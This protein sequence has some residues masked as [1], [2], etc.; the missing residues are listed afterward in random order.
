MLF[1]TGAWLTYGATLAILIGTPS[2]MARVQPSTW[3][4]RAAFALFASSL[5]AEVALFPIGAFV[6]SRVTA[7]GLVVNFAAIPLMTIAQVSGMALLAAAA[8]VPAAVPALAETA[9]RSSWGLVESARLVD[10]A[11]WVTTRLAPPA[12][13]VVVSYYLGWLIWWGVRDARWPGRR[14]IA[15]VRAVRVI[16]L[17]A[18]TGAGL[19]V[20]LAPALNTRLTGTL[21]VTFIDVGQGDATLVRAPGGHAWLIDAG[22]AGGGS[23]DVGRRIVEPVV[24]ARGV[25]RLSRLVLTHGDADHAGGAPSIV[26]DLSPSEIWEGVPVPPDPLLRAVREAADAS[27]ALWRM[28]Q[29]GD[30]VA[31]GAIQATVWHPPPADWERQRVRNDDS[32][33][34]DLRDGDVSIVL[35]G[36]VEAA[37]ESALAALLPPAPIRILLAPHHGSATSST[38]PMIRG[39]KPSLVVISVGRGNRYGHPHRAVLDRYRDAGVPVWRTDLDGAIT[40]RT[41]G[42]TAQVTSFTGRAATLGPAT[43]AAGVQRP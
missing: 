14:A 8:L 2:L 22:G 24:W 30:V 3:L 33:V 9:H 16:G 6:F 12:L 40:V 13:A 41:D 15:L 32:V 5:C 31:A 7:A 23:F 38:W 21:E 34:I 10:L 39:A 36:D 43:R 35:P 37:A 27:G 20:V 29:R 17:A 28:V 4:G 18:A 26:R 42:R 19:W 1:D 25:R 11:P